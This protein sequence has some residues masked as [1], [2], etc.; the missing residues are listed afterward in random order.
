MPALGRAH[1]MMLRGGACRDSLRIAA[2]MKAYKL[3]KGDWPKLDDLV[4][5]YLPDIPKDPFTG[6]DY[7]VSRKDGLLT[8]YSVGEDGT[9]DG[10]VI[11]LEKGQPPDA[12][13]AIGE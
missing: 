1:G 9:D 11:M 4:P 6:R 8:V 12:G 3:E 5:D 10:G 7:V 2:A 13:A